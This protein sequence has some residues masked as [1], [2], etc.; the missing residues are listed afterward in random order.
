MLVEKINEILLKQSTKTKT[1]QFA[2]K[3]PQEN[4]DYSFSNTTPNQVFHTASV[5]K[6]MTTTLIFMAIE[7][8]LISLE[9]NINKL[10]ESSYLTNLFVYQGHD[11]LN[12]VTIQHLLAHTSGVNDYFEGKTSKPKKFIKEVVENPDV[13]YTP[14]DLVNYTRE[15]Q[16][17]VGKPGEKFLYSDTG[18]VLLGLILES[19]YQ[20]PFH[21]VL[22]E[23]ILKPAK[24]ND[25]GLCF[26]SDNF[27]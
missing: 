2:M 13:F 16:Q 12:E 24:M 4:I 26:Y 14:Q 18:F 3:L 20:K 22:E 9:T 11:Y 8:G 19:I 6:F 15:Y 17:V 23:L 21:V 25:S 10:L 7:Q 27:N 5:G 1:L